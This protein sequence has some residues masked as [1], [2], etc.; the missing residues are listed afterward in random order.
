MRLLGQ[1]PMPAHHDLLKSTE[2]DDQN[3][4]LSACDLLD[5]RVWGL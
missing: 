4:S 1:V 5:D 2:T 3:T